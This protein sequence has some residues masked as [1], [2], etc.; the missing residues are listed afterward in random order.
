MSL[1]LITRDISL[2][3]VER[4]LDLFEGRAEI[5]S[6]DSEHVGFSIPTRLLDTVG[7]ERVREVSENVKD[8]SRP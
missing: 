8:R 2:S 4:S 6:V 7:E 3:E 1:Q 5:F